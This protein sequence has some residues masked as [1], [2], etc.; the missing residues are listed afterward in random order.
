[1][2]IGNAIASAAVLAILLGGLATSINLASTPTPPVVASTAESTGASRFNE[3]IK[4]RQERI[5][6]TPMGQAATFNG[7]ESEGGFTGSLEIDVTEADVYANPSDAAREVRGWSAEA[8]TGDAIT[9]KEWPNDACLLFLSVEIKNVGAS[10]LTE[11]EGK[12][13]F[14]FDSISSL[15]C[16][17][18]LSTL[19]C[20]YFVPDAE[21]RPDWLGGGSSTG[22]FQ[23]SPGKTASFT[24][25]YLLVDK[26]MSDAIDAGGLYASGIG[27]YGYRIP[28][29][30]DDKR[31]A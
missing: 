19:E 25:G 8:Y 10:P 13:A 23:L 3:Q 31:G 4:R 16:S 29:E 27:G 2:R 17:T 15:R 26:E 11:K 7:A 1:M 21:R 6:E 22:Y 9:G 12:K 28:L 14:L 20:V 30:I 18:E 5:T 24:V